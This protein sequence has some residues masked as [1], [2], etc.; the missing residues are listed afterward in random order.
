MRPLIF[1]TFACLISF[2]FFSCS[3][4]EGCTD[5]LSL[6]YDPEAIVN[7]GSCEYADQTASFKLTFKP[8]VSNGQPMLINSVYT[9]STGY[10]MKIELLKFYISQIKL[11][12]T[13][14][15]ELLVKDV[16]LIDAQNGIYSVEFDV[17]EGN[18]NKIKFGIGLDSAL[19]ASDPTSFPSSHPLSVYQNTFWSWSTQFR[20]IMFE[21]RS[22]TIIDATQ[23]LNHSFIYHTGTN[24]LYTTFEKNISINISVDNPHEEIIV[25][26]INQLFYNDSSPIDIKSES[27]T[28]TAGSDVPIAIKFTN[29]FKN[30]LL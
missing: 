4:K 3:K 17:K 21:G 14:N 9:D 18:Y 15:N 13:D 2:T 27:L 30:A 16:G 28:H 1:L 23:N 11:T 20:F 24:P 8:I 19:N 7:D 6:N 29:N 5:P 12:D 26:N 25:L 22:D 10:L